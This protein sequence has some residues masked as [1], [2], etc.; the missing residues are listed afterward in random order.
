MR[1]LSRENYF[2]LPNTM[3]R[4]WGPT[5]GINPPKRPPIS[6]HSINYF[7]GPGAPHSLG[8]R[9]PLYVVGFELATSPLGPMTPWPEGS[10][11]PKPVGISTHHMFHP[12][13]YIM[14]VQGVGGDRDLLYL[15]DKTCAT[16]AASCPLTVCQDQTF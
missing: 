6:T 11:H 16:V 12:P 15:C 10:R 7:G 8:P 5:M 14:V 3:P 2:I 13:T 1:R 9:K 4:L